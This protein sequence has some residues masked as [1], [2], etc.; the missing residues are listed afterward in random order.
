MT[1]SSETVE[2]IILRSH[3]VGEADRFL[4]LLTREQGRVSARARAVRKLTSRMGGSLLTGQHAKIQLKELSGGLLVTGVNVVDDDAP[5]KPGDLRAFSLLQR[6]FELLLALTH[7]DE[8]IPEVFDASLAF[9]QTIGDP[10]PHLTLRFAL[11]LLHLLGVLPESGDET[12]F[13][14][15]EE[16]ERAFVRRSATGD[17]RAPLPSSL[18]RVRAAVKGLIAEQGVG[19][20]RAG[21]IVEKLR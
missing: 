4:I 19:K 12:V 15:L 8:P 3:D 14:F 18:E 5:V 17:F 20:L 7:P 9:L 21:E 1:R 13:A 11:R 6:G 16:D 2:A 10:P